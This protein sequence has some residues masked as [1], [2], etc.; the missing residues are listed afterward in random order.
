MAH[1]AAHAHHTVDHRCAAIRAD[2]SDRSERLGADGAVGAG[3]ARAREQ[4]PIARLG[5]PDQRG[6]REDFDQIW[7]VG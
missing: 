4:Q 2:G 6:G 1:R 5:C 3:R 7:K